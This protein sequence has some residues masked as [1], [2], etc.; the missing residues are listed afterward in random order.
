MNRLDKR[1]N[2]NVCCFT[3]KSGNVASD[4][5]RYNSTIFFD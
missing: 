1:F 3:D 4:L 2:E 5:D